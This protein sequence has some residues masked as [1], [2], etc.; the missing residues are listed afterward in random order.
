MGFSLTSFANDIANS[1]SLAS[2]FNN[3][4][5][6]ALIIVAIVLLI[7]FVMFRGEVEDSEYSFWTLL[8]RSGFYLILPIM[9]VVFIHYKN[10][11]REFEQKYENKVLT[12]TVENAVEKNVLGRGEEID[13]E[14]ISG[15]FSNKP[16]MSSTEPALDEVIVESKPKPKA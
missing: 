1:T 6:T 2:I 14:L 4:I 10:T 8:F 15:A 7:I 11:E 5:Y 3:P 12:K 9:G 13:K 16:T